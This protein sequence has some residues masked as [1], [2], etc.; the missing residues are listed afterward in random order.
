MPQIDQFHAQFIKQCLLGSLCADGL[1]LVRPRLISTIH[2]VIDVKRGHAARVAIH[3]HFYS[4]LCHRHT[5][6]LLL[7]S[8]TEAVAA[9]IYCRFRQTLERRCIIGRDLCHKSVR[10]LGSL[11]LTNSRQARNIHRPVIIIRPGSSPFSSDRC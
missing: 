10:S 2:L 5:V 9:L 1:A 11:C 8:E 4:A 3:P 7:V 6:M